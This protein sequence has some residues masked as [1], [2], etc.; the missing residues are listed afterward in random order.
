MRVES[1]AI[2]VR[3]GPSLFDHLGRWLAM[4][5]SLYS[6]MGLAPST[7]GAASEEDARQLELTQPTCSR[8]L[9]AVKDALPESR[10]LSLATA[11]VHAPGEDE[12]GAACDDY[13]RARAA[14][15]TK[16]NHK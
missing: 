16:L 12:A 1:W 15:T 10:E 8:V 5:A 9:E 11:A 7:H 3:L 2:G 4:A 14:L 6:G 13:S